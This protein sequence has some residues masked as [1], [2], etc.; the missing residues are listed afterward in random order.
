METPAQKKW[1]TL[2]EFTKVRVLDFFTQIP[3]LLATAGKDGI[4]TNTIS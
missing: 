4:E 2:C 3:M 1:T